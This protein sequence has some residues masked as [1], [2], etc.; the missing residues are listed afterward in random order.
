V[1]AL[2]ALCVMG[3]ALG[4]AAVSWEARQ[5]RLAQ[6]RAERAQKAEETE[7]IAAESAA[8]KEAE[9][10]RLYQGLSAGLIR[11]RALRHCEEGDT[12]RGLLWLAQSLQ[13]LPNDDIELQYAIRTNLA[14]WHG[15][16]HPLMNMLAHQDSV[17]TALWS[18]GGAL[19]LTAGAD[20]N[21]RLWD[22]ATGLLRGRPIRHPRAVLNAGFSPDGETFLTVAGQELRLWRTATGEPALQPAFDLSN[23]G[24]YI[25]HAF[26]PAGNQL[27]AAT[28][29]GPS[30]WL[31]SWHAD[32][33][34]PLKTEVEIA[35]GVTRVTFSPD[36][37]SFVTA[38]ESREVA[39]RLWRT[40]T[41]EPVR[42]LKEHTH[43]G[44]VIAFNPKDGRSFVTGS[45]DHTCR[46]WDAVTGEPLKPPFRHHAA[47]R[48][49]AF[50]PNG[51]VILA[52]CNDGSAQFWD[53]VKGSALGAPM[54]HADPVGP[55]AFSPDGTL[56]LTVSRDLVHLW[57]AAASEPEPIGSPLPHQKEVLSA[58]FGAEG[59]TVL[60]RGRDSTVRIWQT[61]TARPAGRVLE[62]NGW[63]TALAFHPVGGDSFLA[64]LGAGQGKVVSWGRAVD[65]KPGIAL[66]HLG[67]VLSLAYRPDGR[68]F[69]VG[70]RDQQVRLWDAE[71]RRPA[72]G[73]PLALDERV[74]SLAFSPDGRT[75]L[76]GTAKRRAE[77][78]DVETG[79]KQPGPL[80]HE[81][82]V[83]AVAYSP[84]GQTVMTGSEDMTARLWHAATHEPLGV[85]LVHQG[86]VYAVAFR[87]PDGRVLLTGSDDR[88]ARLW[89]STTGRSLGAAFQHPARVLAA[90]FSPDGRIFAT[91]CGD[92]KA[93]IWDVATGYQIGQSI[94]HRGPVRAL[95]FAPQPSGFAAPAGAWSLVTG[96][97]DKSARV[98]EVFAPTTGSPDH[99]M[100]SL[101]VTNGM[102]LDAQGA[103]ES[104]PPER[105]SR[106]RQEQ[107]LREDRP[108]LGARR[109]RTRL[110]GLAN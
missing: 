22:P 33:G 15:Q 40:A 50:S 56:A 108:S 78:W 86:T 43:F 88:T 49:V 21:V 65:S 71:A 8:A 55:V 58:C 18:P 82:P 14:G 36:G 70:T 31:Q 99:I 32:T 100:R 20:K 54:R 46:L 93:R 67:P 34:R 13:V 110:E 37:Q 90:A 105:W 26:C 48:S 94:L 12:G 29:R 77:F 73:D 98:T 30:A 42:D 97:E 11:D 3:A 60:T 7:R 102:L 92:G 57:D 23:G 41:G 16:S 51:R 38:G 76:A 27:W 53:V 52:G 89:D 17:T 75:L 91:G 61:A 62:H 2:L 35:K 44:T 10:R 109:P 6:G 87:P 106:L 95:A 79:Q 39:P 80:V 96:S 84:D 74:W 83:H 103:A 63:V 104:L 107:S 85:T 66:D 4:F 25:A 69:A 81:K 28:R 45:Y 5:A 68:M 24:Q 59:K 47:V 19:I 64:G 101:E 72:H 9:Q 1:A